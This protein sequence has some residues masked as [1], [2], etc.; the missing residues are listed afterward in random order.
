MMLK[1]LA[2]KIYFVRSIETQK[3]AGV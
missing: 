1:E 2:F 3:T